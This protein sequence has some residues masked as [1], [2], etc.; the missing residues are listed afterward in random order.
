MVKEKKKKKQV[1]FSIGFKIIILLVMLIATSVNSLGIINYNNSRDEMMKQFIGNSEIIA[2]NLDENL[3]SFLTNNE[4]NLEMLSN[5]YNIKDI[6]SMPE[7]EYIYLYNAL[8]NYQEAH[9][10]IQTV[11]LGTHTKQMM[12]FPS[13]S[14]PADFDPTSRPWYQDAVK[15]GKMI[16]TAP[17]VDVG[18]GNVVIT[19]AKPVNSSLGAFTGVVGADISL[20]VFMKLIKETKLGKEGYFFIADS[21]GK[22]IYHPDSSLIDKEIPS[23]ELLDFVTKGVNE[24]QQYEVDGEKKVAIAHKND[25]VNWVIV[26]TFSES[27]INSSASVIL[28]TSA[29]ASVGIVIIAIILGILFTRIFVSRKLSMLVKDIQEIGNGNFKVRS[30]VKSR[31][32]IGV[33]ATTI[34]QMVEQLSEM[35]K[36]IRGISSSVAASSD[37]LSATAQQ[38]NASTEEVVRAIGEVTEAANDQARGTDIGMQRTNELSES[39]QLV[40]ESLE[41]ISSISNVGAELNKTGIDKVKILTEKTEETGSISEEIGRVISEVDN[42]TKEI[43]T[44]TDTIGQIASQTNLLALNASIEAARAGDAGKGFAVVA[45]EI[46]KLAEQSSQAAEQIDALIKGIQEQS[47]I[48]VNTM[49]GAKGAVAAQEIAVK[50]TEGVFNQISETIQGII[51]ELANINEHNDSMQERKNHI[52]EVM[53]SIASA[54][55]QTAASTEEIS[56]STEE[57]LAIVAEI[58]RTAENLNSLAQ[59]LDSEIKKF[60]I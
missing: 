23:A 48:A 7:E 40:S 10:D 37:S 57:Q 56:A 17:Y 15:A 50:E 60:E 54:S 38:T 22:I 33:L 25:K 6:L 5:N 20:D 26:G 45:D 35:L 31:D 8:Q 29:Y 4:Q 19:V 32:E 3:D 59:Q 42:S 43:G 14:L 36:H 46:R 24:T 53:E 21:T 34:N 9:P 28:K 44:I 1:K 52:T 16:W 27:E 18:N 12:L 30:K 41:N 58:S 11:Y 39:I 51:S 47:K 49:E 13:T 55:Q 2:K